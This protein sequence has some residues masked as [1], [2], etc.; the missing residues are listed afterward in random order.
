VCF[1]N[2]WRKLVRI[3]S[4]QGQRLDTGSRFAVGQT[5][6]D[7]VYDNIKEFTYAKAYVRCVYFDQLTFDR[8]NPF[9]E[10]HPAYQAAATL[11]VLPSTPRIARIK[12]GSA[13]HCN[14]DAS[15]T[16]IVKRTRGIDY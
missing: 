16:M 1:L 13:R 11:E 7:R 14:S 10:C 5:F 8:G 3:G 6:Q 15:R 12:M 4:I 9:V 2:K